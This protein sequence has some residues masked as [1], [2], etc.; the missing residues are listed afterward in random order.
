M[1]SSTRNVSKRHVFEDTRVHKIVSTYCTW[2]DV[3][4]E[5]T[6]QDSPSASNM[7]LDIV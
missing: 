2:C 7:I 3:F 4:L 1:K 6:L 5:D